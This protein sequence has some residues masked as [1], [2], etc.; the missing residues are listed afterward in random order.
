MS[1][2]GRHRPT[3]RAETGHRLPGGLDLIFLAV[4]GLAPA[5]ILRHEIPQVVELFAAGQPAP[6]SA[7]D[8]SGPGI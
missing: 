2:R 6:V 8:T 5:W 7:P 3:R 4:I 1:A